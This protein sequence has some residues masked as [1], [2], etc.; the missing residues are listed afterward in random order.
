MRE[1]IALAVRAVATLAMLS[2]AVGACGS[3]ATH[4][5]TNAAAGANTLRNVDGSVDAIDQAR[6]KAATCMR[7]Q[8]I[9]IPDIGVG[10]GQVLQVL[11][12]IA[13]YP[14]AKVQA[15]VQACIREIRQAFPNA[16]SLSPQQRAQDRQEAIV[17]AQCMRSH[18]INFPDPTEA[19]SNLS[20]Y[21][22]ALSALDRN[23]PAYKA[24]AVP[25]RAQALKAAG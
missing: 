18:G 15:A 13:T 14:Q 20:A 10:R 2:I 7:A 22:N 24:A 6:V 23:S 25:C 19:A 4:S 16:T 9:N 8:G 21:V 3:S 11:R 12:I 17:F 5:T 1:R